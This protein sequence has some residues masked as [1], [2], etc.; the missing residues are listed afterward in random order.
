MSYDN[1][2][3]P[4]RV[5]VPPPPPPGFGDEEYYRLYGRPEEYH[6][7]RERLER[8]NQDN[9]NYSQ[10]DRPLPP[11]PAYLH[12][13]PPGRPPRRAPPPPGHDH[14][15]YYY[16]RSYRRPSERNN[17][18]YDDPELDSFSSNGAKVRRA[19]PPPVHRSSD[20]TSPFYESNIITDCEE[21]IDD[22]ESRAHEMHAKDEGNRDFENFRVTI[23]NAHNRRH[24]N[25]EKATRK[26]RA[27]S[28][29]GTPSLSGIDDEELDEE[30]EDSYY[31]DTIDDDSEDEESKQRRQRHRRG[32]EEYISNEKRTPPLKKHSSE[33]RGSIKDRLGSRIPVRPPSP[34]DPPVKRSRVTAPFSPPNKRHIDANRCS[35][36]EVSKRPPSPLSPPPE[37]ENI[38]IESDDDVQVEEPRKSIK[39]SVNSRI[40]RRETTL[41]NRNRKPARSQHQSNTSKTPASAD[42]RARKKNARS[43]S[44]END[45]LGSRYGNRSPTPLPGTPR[46]VRE[47]RAR[48]AAAKKAKGSNE[49]TKS[50]KNNPIYGKSKMRMDTELKQSRTSKD[51]SSDENQE[52][53]GR[54]NNR[55]ELSRGRRSKRNDSRDGGASR[56][57]S[58]REKGDQH[59]RSRTSSGGFGKGVI[60]RNRNRN[61]SD[62]RRPPTPPPIG[63][64]S[65]NK[66]VKSKGKSKATHGEEK[67]PSA[68]IS[69]Q[70]TDKTSRENEMMLRKLAR[71]RKGIP[72][73]SESDKNHTLAKMAGIEVPLDKSEMKSL[74]HIKDEDTTKSKTTTK[75]SKQQYRSTD[76]SNTDSDS[77]SGSGSPAQKGRKRDWKSDVGERNKS[78]KSVRATKGR[79]SKKSSTKENV[80]RH[81]DSESDR[82]EGRSR[83]R[84]VSSNDKSTPVLPIKKTGNSSEKWAHDKFQETLASPADERTGSANKPDDRSD[85]GSHWQKIRSER[86][87]ERERAG[88]SRSRSKTKRR[89]GRRSSSYSS[90]S[91]DDSRTHK[92]RRRTKKSRSSSRG[93]SYSSS[94]SPSTASSSSTGS[95]HRERRRERRKISR[96]DRLKISAENT[97]VAQAAT[98]ASQAILSRPQGSGSNLESQQISESQING[99]EPET[100]SDKA[101]VNLGLSGKLLE[102]SNTVNGVVVKYSEPVEARKPKTRWRLYVFK[103]N[104]EL[105]ILYIHRQSAYLLGRDRKVRKYLTY[106]NWFL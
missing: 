100:I 102:D 16:Y 94:R 86:S 40:S 68:K 47:Q 45:N 7:Y 23:K 50:H 18:D 8:N 36:I 27:K 37:D 28:I 54:S 88:R 82:N 52:R 32:G 90:R 29:D 17:F 34:L 89:K 98:R 25:S 41:S 101:A 43:W 22:L 46:R 67:Q 106:V 2:P 69:R 84:S 85:F 104:E 51:G 35:E 95:I 78:A 105:P 74:K 92:R 76:C 64:K 65:R 53:K 33:K 97:S 103:G 14:E 77:Y 38:D 9:R 70:N 61:T 26:G 21:D 59:N 93:S 72:K 62:S 79:K 1:S 96:K 81:K 63:S 42:R 10:S 91:S 5:R 3:P 20:A 71:K 15:E 66:N 24:R 6:R 83:S 31:D 39:R 12:D 57:S 56:S 48:E 13:V 30:D 4:S 11:R 87:K 19:P 60:G 55:N 73:S 80:K 58:R 75:Q 44:K 99:T 49:K